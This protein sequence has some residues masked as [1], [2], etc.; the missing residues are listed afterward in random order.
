[1]GSGVVLVSVIDGEEILFSERAACVYCGISL[2]EIAPRT[3]SFNSPHGACPTCTGLG[4]QMVIDPELVVTHPELSILQ[5][6]IAPWSK[7]VNGSTW[8]R[9]ILEAVAYRYNFSLE[10]PW[11][12]L[13]EDIQQKL[14]YGSPEPLTIR[15]TNQMGNT[16]SHIVHFKGVIPTLNERYKE[17]ESDGV[18]EEIEGYMSSR[19][20]PDCHGA[21]LKPEAL[22]VTVGGRNIV[23]VSRLS[24][25]LAQRFFQDL[26]AEN[27]ATST[28]AP[29]MQIS[30]QGK[31]KNGNGKN[32]GSV[33]GDPLAKIRPDGPLV[34]G[35]LSERERFIARQV[36][37]EI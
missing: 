10:T 36:L 33:L 35:T 20:C 8:Y 29:I 25:T 34:Q 17:T 1:L 2:P 3:F 13:S 11:Q 27:K 6:A 24:I 4:Q 15:Y 37:K 32:N 12:E 14:L 23:Q 30:G 31:K 19:I 28:P 26:E 18:R 21:R 16:R 5:G 9:T 22:A 7:V